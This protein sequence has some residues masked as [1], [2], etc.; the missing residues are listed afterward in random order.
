MRVGLHAL[1]ALALGASLAATQAAAQRTPAHQNGTLQAGDMLKG[2]TQGLYGRAGGLSGDVNG[3][4]VNPY[5]I[6]D[7]LGLGACTNSASTKATSPYNALCIGHDA[8][9]NGLITLDSYNGL[10]AK[11]LNIR[12]NGTTYAFPPAGIGTGNVVGPAST[13]IGRPALWNNTAGTAL[14][15][16]GPMRVD[17]TTATATLS[18]LNALYFPTWTQTTIAGY[19][20]ALSGGISDAAGSFAD[21]VYVEI[22][23]SDTGI[24]TADH[25]N[26]GARAAA[27]GPYSA[28]WRTSTKNH[29]GFSAYAR[30]ATSS[31]P[32]ASGA[33][34]GV[35]GVF[36]EAVQFGE[37]IADNEFAA[38]NP[39]AAAGGIGQSVSVAGVQAILHANFAD[40][41]STHTAYGLLVTNASTKTAT[42]ALGFSGAGKQQSF[43]DAGNAAVTL[44][45]IRM[46]H[47]DA[48]S[49]GTVIDYGLYNGN[50][51]GGSYTYWNNALPIGALGT[52]IWVNNGSIDF[53]LSNQGAA[54]FPEAAANGLTITPKSGAGN[55]G[56]VL[57]GTWA[58]GIDMASA[59]SI[60]AAGIVMHNSQA[61]SGIIYSTGNYT[62]MIGGAY[63]I[64]TGAAVQ[65]SFQ[66]NHIK[67]TLPANCASSLAGEL[68]NNAGVVSVCP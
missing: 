35:G 28:G 53:T 21:G 5:G 57:G 12:L 17:G 66:T 23:D 32:L 41:D 2:L 9:G 14:T 6:S 25:T 65:A 39:D 22:T 46:P 18:S 30:G 44:A 19:R 24:Y 49:A 37:G 33:R 1:A 27:F 15:D 56:T 38:W 34:P 16:L 50:P 4:G 20:T 61:G 58:T 8:S 59:T 48:G 54:L 55:I 60:T 7:A 62:Q 13:T 64:V 29:I 47:S 10:A 45:A 11:V 51:A 42:A 36:G 68:Y 26:Y 67:L 40:A 43:I 31:T 63:T 3:R 52:Y